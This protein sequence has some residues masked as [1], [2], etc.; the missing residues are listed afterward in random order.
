M[1]TLPSLHAVPASWLRDGVLA[2]YIGGYWQHLVR[3][4]YAD[5]TAR[6][7]LY[8]IAH[9]ARWIRRRRIAACDLTDDAVR[10]FIAEHL[11]HCT[12]PPPVRRH[13]RTIRAALRHL[14]IALD[15]AGVLRKDKIVSAID[16]ELRRFDEYMN[17][18]RG[19]ARSTRMQRLNILRAFLQQSHGAGSRVPI[20]PTQDELRRFIDRQLRRLCPASAK[21]VAGTL[22]AYLRYRATLGDSVVHLLPVITSPANRR[23]AA[24]PQTLSQQEVLQ[25]LDAFPQGLPSR[26]RAYAMVRC[27]VD[28]GLRAGEVVTIDLDDIDWEAGTLRIAKNKSRRVDVLPLPQTTGQAIATYLR[29]ERP[30]TASR[31]V[32]V[33]HVAP[34]DAPIGPEVL[35]KIVREAYRRSG[36]PHTRVHILRH[37]LASRMLASGSTLKEVA[38]VLRHRELD[39]SMIYTKVDMVRLSAVAMPWPGGVT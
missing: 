21:V 12:C 3:R 34:V 37:T 36:L 38:D 16:D 22:R 1:G 7:Y 9:F 5:H 10:R 30:P 14:L 28:L 6:M 24:L 8:C 32:F 33:R 4:G 25:L 13:A 2:P 17:R 19:L 15:E 35:R 18:A 39:T 23:L 11:P 26:H 20:C 27:L 31:R 29:A